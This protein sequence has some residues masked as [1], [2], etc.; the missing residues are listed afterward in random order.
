MEIFVEWKH[1]R[2]R[3]FRLLVIQYGG[4]EKSG[5]NIEENIEG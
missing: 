1:E 5:N 3:D 4:L 2:Y